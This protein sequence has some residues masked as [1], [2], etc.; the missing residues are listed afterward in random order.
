MTTTTITAIKAELSTVAPLADQLRAMQAAVA[1]EA[2]LLAILSRLEAQRIEADRA[3]TLKAANIAR[4]QNISIRGAGKG[5]PLMD[6]YTINFSETVSDMLTMMPIQRAGKQ[7]F[8]GPSTELY[9]AVLADP[10]IL[11]SAIRAL[12]ADPDAAIRMYVRGKARGFLIG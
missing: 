6:D 8:T 7:P 3:A 10:E 9:A 1:R 11:P 12:D 4:F 5:H 2:E